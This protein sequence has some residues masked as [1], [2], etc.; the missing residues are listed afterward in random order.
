MCFVIAIICVV[1]GIQFFLNSL[2]LYAFFAS[3][4]ALFFIVLMV[5]NVLHVKK[6]KDK[7]AN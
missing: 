7:N 5:K 2:Y 1:L 6:L 3:V 4:T